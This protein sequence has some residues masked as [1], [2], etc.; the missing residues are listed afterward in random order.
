MIAD[1]GCNY[2]DFESFSRCPCLLTCRGVAES[3][4]FPVACILC[5]LGALLN[6]EPYLSPV[7]GQRHGRQGSLFPISPAVQQHSLGNEVD[8]ISSSPLVDQPVL[9]SANPGCTQASVLICW[10]LSKQQNLKKRLIAITA[11]GHI[12]SS[13]LACTVWFVL[14][15]R[16]YMLAWGW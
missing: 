3:F 1:S 13:D 8:A 9:I 2:M 6:T 16:Y 10:S 12:C 14:L 4:L 11:V 7:E 5:C 15:V